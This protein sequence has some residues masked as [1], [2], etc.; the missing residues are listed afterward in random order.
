MGNKGG[1]SSE[2]EISDHDRAVL[3]LKNARDTLKQYQKVAQPAL[4]PPPSSHQRVR[5]KTEASMARHTEVAR[6][7]LRQG[8]K[9]GALVVVKRKKMADFSKKKSVVTRTLLMLFVLIDWHWK[10]AHHGGRPGRRRRLVC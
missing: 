6:E 2:V 1:K 4:S 5:Q 3:D 9:K 10:D 8:N 7:L